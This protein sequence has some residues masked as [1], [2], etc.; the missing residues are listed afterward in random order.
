MPFPISNSLTSDIFYL[1]HCDT[2]GPFHTPTHAGQ[3]FFL[4]A[5]D[6]FS[7]FTWVFLMAHKSEAPHLL[8]NFCS[9]VATQFKKPVKCIRSDNAPELSLQ[10]FTAKHGIDHQFSCAERRKQNSFVECKHQ[11]L[12]NVA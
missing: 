6:D 5:V 1:V 7:C 8:E 10:E 11:H 12:L 9:Y 4:T 3:C 2:W